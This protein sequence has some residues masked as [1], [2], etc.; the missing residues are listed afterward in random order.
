[1]Y[2]PATIKPPP[3]ASRHPKQSVPS[4]GAIRAFLISLP[5]FRFSIDDFV[6]RLRHYPWKS[7]NLKV[8]RAVTEF[9]VFSMHSKRSL[10][11]SYVE[12]G[13]VGDDNLINCSII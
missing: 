6:F 10:N 9:L 7:S 11:D 3:D 5:S 13:G 4:M 1:M 12:G 2:V 8:I